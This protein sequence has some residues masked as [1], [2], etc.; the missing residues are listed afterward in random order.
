[1]MIYLKK[2]DVMKN[3]VQVRQLR[4]SSK[5]LKGHFDTLNADMIFNFPGQTPKCSMTI[6]Q[7]C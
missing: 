2:S 1:M 7:F 4:K 3:T 6:C 5:I